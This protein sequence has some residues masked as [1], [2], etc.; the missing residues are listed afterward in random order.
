MAKNRVRHNAAARATHKGD[1]SNSSSSSSSSINVVNT[2]S[3]GDEVVAM[4]ILDPTATVVK[5]KINIK[6][7]IKDAPEQ[8]SRKKRKRLEAYIEKKLKKE[9][10]VQLMEKLATSSFESNLLK[11]SAKLGQAK[12]TKKEQLRRALHEERLGVQISADPSVSLYREVE[13]PAPL[14]ATPDAP[15]SA[16]TVSAPEPESNVPMVVFDGRLSEPSFG[17]ALKKPA[18]ASRHP[19]KKRKG[20]ATA[21]SHTLG[22]VHL[23]ASSDEESSSEDETSAPALP[24]PPPVPVP[25][26]VDEQEVIKSPP[27]KPPVPGKKS[28]YVLVNRDAE[29]QESRLRLPVVQ[30]EHEIMDTINHHDVVVICGETGSGK[31]TQVP[32]FLYEAGYSSAG[33]DHPGIIG[34]TQPRRVAAV[35][36]A[37]RVATE[38]GLSERVVSHQIRYDTTTSASTAIKFMTDGVLLKE[39]ATDF[40]LT[41]YSVVIIDEAHERNLNTDILIGVLSRIVKLRQQM[42]QKPGSKVTVLKLIIMSATLRVSDFT[43]NARLFDVPPPVIN[44]EARQYP[45]TVHFNR[46]T[47]HIDHVTEAYKKACKIHKRLPHGGILIFLTGQNEIQNLVHKLRTK[48]PGKKAGQRRT[49]FG[50]NVAPANEVATDA[51]ATVQDKV[52]ELDGNLTNSATV[53]VDEAAAA[54]RDG[55]RN[56]DV[57]VLNDDGDNTDADREAAAFF[58]DSEDDD[59]DGNDSDV[60]DDEETDGPDVDAAPLHVLPLY[61]LLPTSQ[62]MRV[63]EAVPEGARLCVVAT[64]VAETSLTIP[65]IKYVIDCGKV[66][67]RRYDAATSVQSYAIAWTSK[68]SADQ[69]AGRAGRTGPGHCYRLYSSAVF[70]NQFE[71]FSRPEILKMPIEGVVLQLK[72]MNIDQVVNFPFPTPPVRSDLAR[73]EKLLKSLGALD[74]DMRCTELGQQMSLFPVHPR[75]AKM[76]MLGIQQSHSQMAQFVMCI[77]AAMSVGDPFVRESNLEHDGDE[78]DGD[79]KAE[80]QQLRKRW[81]TVQQRYAGREPTSDVLKLLNVLGAFEF[82]GAT[83]QFCEDNFLRHKAMVEMR[84]LRF[85]LAAI[86]QTIFPSASFA[87]DPKTAPPTSK[88]STLL[89][90]II[91]AGFIDHLAIVHPNPPPQYGKRQVTYYQTMQTDE[92][93]VVHMTSVLLRQAVLPKALVF[94]ELL[95]TSKGGGS[96]IN[97]LIDADAQ[98]ADVPSRV[99]MKCLTA[100]EL[101]WIVKVVPSMCTFGKPME[102][103]TPRYSKDLDTVTCFTEPTVGPHAWTLPLAEVPF[104]LLLSG[105]SALLVSSSSS[106]SQQ[107]PVDAYKWFA[108]SLLEG[109]V[110]PSELWAAMQPHWL[111]KPTMLT[112]ATFGNQKRIADLVRALAAHNILSR[113]QLVEAWAKTPSYLLEQVKLWLPADQHNKLTA[114][115]PPVSNNSKK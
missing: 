1:K 88:Q 71:Q 8:M 72:S 5:A 74:A 95:R 82:A 52:S 108:R 24:P 85:Q 15:G 59:D 37:R 55:D 32:Q 62:Q 56:A 83:E 89:R 97:Y 70:D 91:L 42:S 4:D 98:D 76:L 34:V 16:L 45:V 67:E 36:M 7:H 80:R 115:W 33:S 23:N 17:S 73:A 100:V 106:K 65:N 101:D 49:I 75:F 12:E 109:K 35:S 28:C 50:T 58:S 40:L 84:N 46:R 77:V 13:V 53:D 27:R 87:V 39:L 63:F 69:R 110:A 104:R 93:T 99:F 26:E 51:S 2:A 64:N 21:S 29:I 38:L 81:Y 48:F 113:K 19:A 66:K 3:A 94:T 10:R 114:A 20:A 103:P 79:S 18:P 60:D 43:E 57:I 41:R 68:A 44:V 54:A 22:S 105:H 30:S 78:G 96:S 31:T 14:A 92:P 25:E 102:T 86:L 90:Q 11:S 9:E 61:S 111:S 47:P 107:A 6:E 112:K